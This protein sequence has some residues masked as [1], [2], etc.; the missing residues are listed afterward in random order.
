MLVRHACSIKYLCRG[1]ESRAVVSLN[2]SPPPLTAGEASD[3]YEH[4]VEAMRIK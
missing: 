2:C 1:L 3:H 4:F